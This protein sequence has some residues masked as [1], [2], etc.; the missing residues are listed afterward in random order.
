MCPEQSLA[1][2]RFQSFPQILV[3]RVKTRVDDLGGVVGFF[4]WLDLTIS[5]VFE[6]CC[7]EKKYL[8]LLEQCWGGSAGGQGGIILIT[9]H[10]QLP[11]IHWA[12][13]LQSTSTCVLFGI[14]L[15]N[16]T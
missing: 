13:P 9:P 15:A 6:C 10:R 7:T 5:S 12:W 1:F 4:S 14:G 8:G 2:V 3:S 11:T 16:Q